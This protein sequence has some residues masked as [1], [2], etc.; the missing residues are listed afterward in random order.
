[1]YIYI[2]MCIYAPPRVTV[3]R[4]DLMSHELAYPNIDIHVTWPLLLRPPYWKHFGNIEYPTPETTPPAHQ[5]SNVE[6]TTH[7]FAKVRKNGMFEN[8]CVFPW[9]DDGRATAP[10]RERCDAHDTRCLRTTFT[11]QSQGARPSRT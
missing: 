2:Y 4:G 10:A 3:S 5:N 11:R 6:L 8:T 7:K 9:K 1:M